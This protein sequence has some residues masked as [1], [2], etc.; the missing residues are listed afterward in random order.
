LRTNTLNRSTDDRGR[1]HPDHDEF[2]LLR[3]ST[4]N[5]LIWT[6]A[7]TAI[8]SG[9]AQ[10]ILCRHELKSYGLSGD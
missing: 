4:D 7:R 10:T 6:T 5:R 1:A 8:T 9:L 2:D 3:T